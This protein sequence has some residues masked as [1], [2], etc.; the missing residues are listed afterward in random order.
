MHTHR[1]FSALWSLLLWHFTQKP[2]GVSVV[3][4][5]VLFGPEKPGL[6]NLS[7]RNLAEWGSPVI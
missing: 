2:P 6:R 3:L 5:T 7:I 1:G 4:T